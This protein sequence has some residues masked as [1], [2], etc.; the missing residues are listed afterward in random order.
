MYVCEGKKRGVADPPALSFKYLCGPHCHAVHP[1]CEER[2]TLPEYYS[3][4]PFTQRQAQLW[5]KEVM[6]VISHQEYVEV[7]VLLHE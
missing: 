1:T 7:G 4:L 2:G 6:G 5:G 3:P